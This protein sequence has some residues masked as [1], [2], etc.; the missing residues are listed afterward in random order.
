MKNR[1]GKFMAL[2]LF[3]LIFVVACS[4]A[5]QPGTVEAINVKENAFI[6]TRQS[7]NFF[8]GDLVTINNG[9]DFSDLQVGKIYGLQIKD[10][11]PTTVPLLPLLV[12]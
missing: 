3:V 10:E 12:R 7:E 9:G 2:L 5:S 8:P 11:I 4:N 6:I 1:F